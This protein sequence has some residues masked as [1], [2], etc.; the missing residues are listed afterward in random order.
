MCKNAKSGLVNNRTG[1]SFSL[2]CSCEVSL[3]H[4]LGEHVLLIR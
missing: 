4:I 2:L 1:M 3:S